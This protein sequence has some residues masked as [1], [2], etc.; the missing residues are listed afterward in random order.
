MVIRNIEYRDA[1]NFLDMLLH[2]DN[3][4]K[5][6][7]YEP[8]ERPKDIEY[9]NSMIQHFESEKDLI[10]IANVSGKIVGYL[11]AEKGPFNRVKHSAFVVV[12]IL[13]LFH[14]QGIGSALFKVLED[15][16]IQNK[17]TRLELTVMCNNTGAIHLYEK[18]GF[19]IEGV[20][21]NSIMVDDKCV[22]EY[23]MAKLI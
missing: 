5:Y 17:I 19:E 4:T 21:R 14:G 11:T 8:D 13:S 23:Y 16:A 3:E 2:L 10:L 20:K 15:W 9:I 1:E 7:M 6:M 12:G 18:N 22:D